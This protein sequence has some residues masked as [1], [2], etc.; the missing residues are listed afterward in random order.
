MAEGPP[1]L[2]ANGGKSVGKHALDSI[3]A[4]DNASRPLQPQVGRRSRTD[5]VYAEVLHDDAAED[6]RR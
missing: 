4:D 5:E 3:R 1:S 2:A 6:L